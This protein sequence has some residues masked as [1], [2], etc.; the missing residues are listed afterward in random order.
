MTSEATLQVEPRNESGKSAARRLRSRG[1]VPGNLY[2]REENSLSVQMDGHDVELLISRIS[3]ENTLVELTVKG[4]K[5][6]R[7]LIRE[8]QRHPWRANILHVDFYEITAGEKIKV[9]VPLRLVGTPVGVRNSGGIL[10]QNRHELEIEVLPSEIPD[11][12]EVDV[13]ELEIGDSLHVADVN[14]GGVA[15]TEELHLTVCAVQ[16]PTVIAEP[17]EEEGEEI[18][19]EEDMEPEVITARGDEEGEDE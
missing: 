13:T 16:P 12:F 1:L 9:S 11:A 6:R 19:G 3:V 18:E 7:V 2:G 15:P 5:P 17:E 4:G 10:Q 8:I 14:T